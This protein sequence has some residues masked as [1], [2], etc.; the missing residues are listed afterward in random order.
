MRPC[1]YFV[2]GYHP[3]RHG[4]FLVADFPFPGAVSFPSQ[5]LVVRALT[6]RRLAEKAYKWYESLGYRS[7]ALKDH[8]ADVWREF[9]SEWHEHDECTCERP[10]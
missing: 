7:V 10:A 8:W 5:P 3:E 2:T 4:I 9:G 1:R 6:S